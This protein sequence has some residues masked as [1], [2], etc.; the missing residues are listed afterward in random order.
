MAASTL[1][2]WPD[3]EVADGAM[4]QRGGGLQLE[5]GRLRDAEVE[6]FGA[7]FEIEVLETR[8][9]LAASA[10]LQRRGV[11]RLQETAYLLKRRA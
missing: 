2:G 3:A 11:T 6:L 10:N 4:G 7:A 1:R 8:D 9:G 5:L